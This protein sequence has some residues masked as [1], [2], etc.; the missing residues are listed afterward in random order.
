MTTGLVTYSR[1][2]LRTEDGLANA[3][4][5]SIRHVL[6]PGVRHLSYAVFDQSHRRRG[7]TIWDGDG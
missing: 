1:I 4:V 2:N 6:P 5:G 3:V 7:L